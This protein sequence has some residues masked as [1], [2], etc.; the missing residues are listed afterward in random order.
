MYNNVLIV[1]KKE[2]YDLLASRLI[3]TVIAIYLILIILNVNNFYNIFSDPST[4]V[5]KNVNGNLSLLMLS[6]LINILSG[7]GA[8]VGIMI[9]SNSIASERRGNALNT[10]L[11]KPV[12]R[13]TVINGKLLGVIGFFICVFSIVILF[14][15]S[16]MFIICGNSIAP[17]IGDYITR[18]PVILF[19]S[20]IFITFFIVLSML[21]GILVKNQAFSLLLSFIAVFLS[22][23]IRTTSFAGNISL[24]FWMD[25]YHVE[26]VIRGL[27]PHGIITNFKNPFLEPS[28]SM[29]AAMNYVE[30]EIFRLIIFLLVVLVLCYIA[31][32]RRD[33]A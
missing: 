28:L 25:R 12:Y 26:H 20:L 5:S 6:I 11:V 9:G 29:S 16:A 21:M 17:F 32:M 30:P 18:L 1:A 15:T 7:Y 23:M 24:L 19:T 14:F 2:F 31:F 3:L 33:I 10:L 13:D 22:D 8:I 4:N 27:S